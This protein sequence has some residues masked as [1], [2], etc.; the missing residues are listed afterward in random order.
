MGAYCQFLAVIDFLVGIDVL[1][2]F[3]LGNN[4]F[5]RV[6]LVESLLA[7]LGEAVLLTQALVLSA[8]TL[9]E[10]VCLQGAAGRKRAK[11]ES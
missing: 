10:P 9:E 6:F 5:G 7:G 11:H 2:Q 8:G 3:H 4:L 1:G